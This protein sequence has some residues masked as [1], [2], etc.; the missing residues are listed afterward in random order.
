MGDV[1]YRYRQ[2]GNV[3]DK[4]GQDEGRQKR[5]DDITRSKCF[6]ISP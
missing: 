4:A 1:L 5:D 3:E 6:S 2:T